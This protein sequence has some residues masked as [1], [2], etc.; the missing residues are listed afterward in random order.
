MTHLDIKDEK[1]TLQSEYDALKR[2]LGEMLLE[3]NGKEENPEDFAYFSRKFEEARSK[4]R[5]K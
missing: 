4:L 1:Q 5:R 3:H 2:H